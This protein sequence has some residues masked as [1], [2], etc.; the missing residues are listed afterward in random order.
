MTLA[1]ISDLHLNPHYKRANVLRTRQILHAVNRLGADHVVVTGDITS[2]ALPEDFA[3]ARDLFAEAGL[4]QGSRLTMVIGNHDIFGGVHTAE[5]VLS[6]PG[7]CRKAPYDRRVQ[8]FAGQFSEAFERTL[9]VSKESPFPFVKMVN[10]VVLIGINSVARYSGV[11]NPLGSNGWV[12]D[13]QLER[14]ERL[15]GSRLFTGK[16]KIVL[17]H[18]HFCKLEQN[19]VGTMH[20]VW[21]TIERQTMKLRGKKDLLRLFQQHG[22]DLV[23][24]GHYH[25]TMEYERKGIRFLNGGGSVMDELSKTLTVNIV[26]VSGRG[27]DVAAH[28]IP[29][30]SVDEAAAS[31]LPAPAVLDRAA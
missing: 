26:R 30:E 28:R 20:S 17:I 19:G 22:I 9:T 1:H 3:V 13:D 31:R 5:D 16:R 2:G 8:E 29:L 27:I 11:R 14:F 12:D 24:H 15:V 7:K 18:H 10:D 25:R 21:G 4:L 23:L 6:F